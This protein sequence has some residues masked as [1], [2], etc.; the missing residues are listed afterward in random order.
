[1]ND[2]MRENKIEAVA[3]QV[4]AA[5][6]EPKS[7]EAKGEAKAGAEPAAEGAEKKPAKVATAKTREPKAAEH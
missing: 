6:S 5:R 4:V 1:M 7:T 3:P 2:Y